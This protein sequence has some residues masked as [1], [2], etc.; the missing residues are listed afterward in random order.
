MKQT[1]KPTQLKSAAMFDRYKSFSIRRNAT[2][3]SRYHL[4]ETDVKPGKTTTTT[5]TT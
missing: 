1:N 4:G 2:F 5:T 3:F